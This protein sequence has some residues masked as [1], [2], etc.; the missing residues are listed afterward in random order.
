[1]DHFPWNGSH[2]YLFTCEICIPKT[3]PDHVR[4]LDQSELTEIA[5]PS[6]VACTRKVPSGKRI[7]RQTLR[8]GES[9]LK[10]CVSPSECLAMFGNTENIPPDITTAFIGGF[11]QWICSKFDVGSNNINFTSFVR[12]TA[13]PLSPPVTTIATDYQCICWDFKDNK[14]YRRVP[15]K[16][17]SRER[18]VLG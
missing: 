4:S 11:S 9:W 5:G 15:S 6:T 10:L 14:M 3:S 1:M 7:R 18:A 17:I 8:I 13:E 16:Y 2:I 12:P